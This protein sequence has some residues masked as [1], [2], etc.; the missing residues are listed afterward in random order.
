MS[1][2]KY[3]ST[4]KTHQLKTPLMDDPYTLWDDDLLQTILNGI[5]IALG[6][7]IGIYTFDAKGI[8]G[9]INHCQIGKAVAASSIHAK[10]YFLYTPHW[11]AWIIPR[12]YRTKQSQLRIISSSPRQLRSM[13]LTIYVSQDVWFRRLVLMF[14]PYIR[15]NIFCTK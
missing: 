11:I 15:T 5:G 12:L 6:D 9:H 13:F 2:P 7:T 4:V 14:A 8:T 3:F 10:C 1:L